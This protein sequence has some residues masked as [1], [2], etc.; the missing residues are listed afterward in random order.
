MDAN[1]VTPGEI[2]T[3]YHQVLDWKITQ[4]GKQLLVLNLLSI[5]WLVICAALF[6]LWK[7]AWDTIREFV[8]T[9]SKNVTAG[10]AASQSFVITHWTLSIL[11]GVAVMV[12]LHELV[13]GLTMRLFGA[14]PKYGVLLSGLMFM[15]P[16]LVLLFA[17]SV[18]DGSPRSPGDPQRAAIYILAMPLSAN[19]ATFL[20]CAA[21]S[22]PPAPL[23]ICGLYALSR[24]TRLTLT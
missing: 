21:H 11:A 4:S 19:L 16:L 8:M 18:S 20:S 1:T 2:P 12:V 23:A 10:G 6:V 22:M 3:G 13:H 14:K 24:A 9:G 15:L 7:M 5:P 17:Q